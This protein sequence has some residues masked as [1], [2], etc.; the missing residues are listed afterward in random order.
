MNEIFR[1]V[2][3]NLNWWGKL[4]FVYY[5]W[6]KVSRT[7][8]GVAFGIDPE[9]QGKGIGRFRLPAGEGLQAGRIDVLQAALSG[10][11]AGTVTPILAREDP[12]S[13]ISP[14]ERAVLELQR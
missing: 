3:G 8:I 6:R 2:N 11:N 10:R 9:F 13:D 4:K 7:C 14:L 12:G 5:R 1:Y